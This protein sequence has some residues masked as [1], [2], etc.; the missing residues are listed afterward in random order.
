MLTINTWISKAN[1]NVKCLWW[2]P[3]KLAFIELATTII[4]EI[5]KDA[6]DITRSMI[7]K[8]IYKWWLLQL[9][10]SQ[11]IYKLLRHLPSISCLRLFMIRASSLWSPK[12]CNDNRKH[13]LSHGQ[14]S[15]LTHSPTPTTRHW[16]L[17]LQWATQ[18]ARFM[19]PTWGPP[20]PCR[21]QM[22]PMLVPWTLL[23]GNMG[24]PGLIR[25]CDRGIFPSS[26]GT[27]IFTSEL[28][29]FMYGVYHLTYYFL[30]LGLIDHVLVK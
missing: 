13:V 6:Y 20:G 5:T 27:C 25:D 11:T 2:L 30:Y 9:E 26:Q 15:T 7:R 29:D 4:N 12:K 22:G 14:S 16:V 19:G 8:R 24:D 28:V 23:S 10:F 21:P 17:P 3:E 1:M 18:I